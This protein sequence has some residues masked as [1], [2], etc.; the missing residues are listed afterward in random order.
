MEYPDGPAV[1]ILRGDGG[2]YFQEEASGSNFRPI[3]P[4]SSA[5]IWAVKLLQGLAPCHVTF[6]GDDL[7]AG[8]TETGRDVAGNRLCLGGCQNRTDT[9]LERHAA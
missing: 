5:S 1:R 8:L 7:L 6:L 3:P 4:E 9:G 2:L